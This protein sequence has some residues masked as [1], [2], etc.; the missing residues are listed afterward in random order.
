MGVSKCVDSPGLGF[1][2]EK[3]QK[4]IDKFFK[5]FF[6]MLRLVEKNVDFTKYGKKPF[7]SRIKYITSLQIEPER[8]VGG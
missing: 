6:F 7:Q 5:N 2:C 3:N 4:K 1:K 8:F